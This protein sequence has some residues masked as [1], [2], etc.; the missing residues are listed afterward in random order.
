M[1][2]KLF[3]ILSCVYLISCGGGGGSEVSPNTPVIAS[4]SGPD[5]TLPKLLS[6]QEMITLELNPEP[7]VFT[8]YKNWINDNTFSIRSVVYDKDFSDLEFLDNAIKERRLVQLGESSHGSKEFNHLKVRLIKYLHQNL[9]FNVIAFE[10]SFFGVNYANKR[11]ES[12]SAELTMRSIFGPWH[13]DEVIELF[14][15]LKYTRTTSNPLILTGFDVQ[16]SGFQDRFL[17]DEYEKYFDPISSEFTDSLITNETLITEQLQNFFN[18]SC[19]SNNANDNCS[20]LADSLKRIADTQEA[21]YHEALQ[22]TYNYPMESYEKFLTQNIKSRMAYI[23]QNVST[24]LQGSSEG[25]NT[26]DRGMFENLSFLLTNRYPNEKVIVWA[27]NGHIKYQQT[28]TLGLNGS[29]QNQIPMGHHLFQSFNNEL[30]TIG[31]YMIRGT[32]GLN[33]SSPQEVTALQDNSLEAISYYARKAALFVPIDRHG[34]MTDENQFIYKYTPYKYWGAWDLQQV[35]SDQFDGI[36]IVDTSS[37]PTY[38]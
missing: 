26:R 5:L 36:I 29:S 21:L 13:T 2:R 1:H 24:F 10:S 22:L 18:N 31:L 25:Y 33:N 27:H 9:G 37:M 8:G 20:T 6:D 34:S 28:S 17:L 16:S 11:I 30:Y 3:I 32:S 7:E 15:Y 12:S 19:T 38:R 35:L 14:S 23:N 4:S